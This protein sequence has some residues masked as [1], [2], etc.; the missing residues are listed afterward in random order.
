MA[1]IKVSRDRGV[2]VAMHHTEEVGFRKGLQVG[3][4]TMEHCSTDKLEQRQ[5]DQFVEKGMAIVPTLKALGDYFEIEEMLDWLK[6]K[7]SKDFMPEPLSQTTKGVELLL[8][9]PYPPP[10][11]MEK[12]YHDIE[13]F[14]KGCPVTVK[15][16]EQIKNA[17]G[18]IG[19]GT[20]TCGTGLSFFGFYWK[21]LKHLT[22]AGLSNFEALKAAT[23]VN[24]EIIGMEGDVG[25]IK[26]GKYADF[27][28][29]EGNPLEDIESVKDVKIVIKGGQS[30]T[31]MI[32][33]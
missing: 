1:L 13:F 20:D 24:A 2:K 30:I 32:S 9:K 6:G 15:N 25:S 23:S 18:K 26:P 28:I 21:E 12:Y 19:V 5:I 29:I 4:D 22:E 10:D 8:R 17:G 31:D 27:T 3:V 14:K 16:I 33:Q 7:G 11:Y